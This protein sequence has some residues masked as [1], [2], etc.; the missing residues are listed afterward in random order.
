MR[1]RIAGYKKHTL[2]NGPGVRFVLFMQG[3]PHHCPGCQNPET[4]N[5]A[6]GQ[7]TDTEEIIRL[8]RDTKFLDGIT[9]SGGDPLY[10]PEAAA[11]IAKAAKEDGLSVW[12]YT[13]WTMEQILAGALPATVTE[14]LLPQVDV[15]VDG[16]F[17]QS[18]LSQDC[19]YRGSDNQR[20]L[21]ARETLRTGKAVLYNLE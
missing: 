3:C 9:L 20:L 18:R 12:C 5:P 21:D 13:G 1:V 10:Q 14:E 4:W 2:V 19:I 17:I 11:L 7:E 8:I 16:P 6:G 15:L